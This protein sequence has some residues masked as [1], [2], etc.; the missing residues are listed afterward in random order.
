MSLSSSSKRRIPAVLALAALLS[1]PLPGPAAASRARPRPTHPA[2]AAISATSAISMPWRSLAELWH[3]L[4]ASAAD[5][6]CTAADPG[7]KLPTD[8]NGGMIDPNGVPKTA[9]PHP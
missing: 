1:F 5:T 6:A 3:L 8:D 9:P 2:S 7:G 4:T